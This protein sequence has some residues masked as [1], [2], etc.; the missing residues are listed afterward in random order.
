MRATSLCGSGNARLWRNWITA[1]NHPSIDA[2]LRHG[3]ADLEAELAA[4]KPTCW[5]SGR[6]C[7]FE[8]YGHK[9][10]VTGLEIAWLVGQLDER[11][12]DRLRDADPTT[13]G[14]PFQIEKLCSVHALRPLGCRIF[15]CDANAQ[16]WQNEVYET[17]LDRLRRLHEAFG[18]EYRYMEWR[19]GLAEAREAVSI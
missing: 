10:Y 12:R 14:C 6:C 18:L 8:S 11:G 5:L 15:F 1:A 7:K 19:E 13:D 17:F 3:Y 4:L 9:L 2:A 16:H